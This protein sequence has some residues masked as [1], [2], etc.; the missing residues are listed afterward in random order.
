MKRVYLFF[1]L[2]FLVS[3]SFGQQKL[4]IKSDLRDVWM[5]FDQDRYVKL[6]ENTDLRDVKAIHFNIDVRKNPDAYLRVSL[7]KDFS[8]FID[9]QLA[10]QADRELRL[11]LDS[12]A[13]AFHSYSFLVTVYQKDHVQG[14]QTAIVGL[15]APKKG[16]LNYGLK[17][18]SYFR[19]FVVVASLILV[20][21]LI[22]IVNLNP[23]LARDY[24]SVTRIFSLRETED[25]QIYSRITGSINIL[26]YVFCSLILGF[27][28]LII[29]HFLPPEYSTSVEFKTAGFGHAMLRWVQLSFILLAVFFL[30]IIVIYSLSKL[31]GLRDLAG[32]H[33]FNWIRVLLIIF[34]L[35]SLV[36]FVYFISRGQNVNFFLSMLSLV[37]VTLMGW[38]VLVFFKLNG[39]VEHSLFHLF[40]YICA[41]EIIPLLITITV[42]YQ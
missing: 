39:K 42:L 22:V 36:L 8:V 1:Q 2:L 14:L 17:P 11:R 21:M 41:T 30:K 18:P 3:S 6:D 29:F 24:F 25:S 26:F 40:S 31:F 4:V 28:L 12:L 10:A 23:K 37:T 19:D 35:A 27:Y 20:V 33:F 5:K 13:E 16:G 7:G 9:H 15:P 34:G 38:I 32:L